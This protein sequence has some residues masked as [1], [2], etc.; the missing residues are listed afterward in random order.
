MKTIAFWISWGL[1]AALMLMSWQSD[2]RRM[3]AQADAAYWRSKSKASELALTVCRNQARSLASR[4]VMICQP[5]APCPTLGER[6]RNVW[7]GGQ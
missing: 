6:I 2:A 3:E 5:P 4:P 1:V 7:E